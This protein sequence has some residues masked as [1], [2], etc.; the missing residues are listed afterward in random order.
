M[1]KILTG[2][3][4][5]CSLYSNARELKFKP[6]DIIFHDIGEWHV[7]NDRLLSD[8]KKIFL[9]ALKTAL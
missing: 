1:R 5:L 2:L 6:K 7:T 9:F 8:L 4:L 3:I